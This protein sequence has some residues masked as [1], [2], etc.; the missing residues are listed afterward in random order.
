MELLIQEILLSLLGYTGDLI[1]ESKNGFVM[2]PGLRVPGSSEQDQ[3][4]GIVQLGWYY[5]ELDDL[6]KKRGFN[7]NTILLKQSKRENSSYSMGVYN[8]ISDLCS[9]YMSDVCHL[10]Q[11][12][13]GDEYISIS[14]ISQHLQKY[15]VIFPEI[16]GICLE[17]GENNISGC[18]LL[19]YFANLKHGNPVVIDVISRI[20]MHL[21]NIFLKQC[22]S[23]MLL[24]ELDDEN[25]EFF[26]QSNQKMSRNLSLHRN[27]NKK[28]KN[29]QFLEEFSSL[30]QSFDWNKTFSLKLDMI[31]VA[32]VNSRIA[33]KI[34]FC[35]KAVKLLNASQ[36]SWTSSD[37]KNSLFDSLESLENQ[38]FQYLL[39]KFGFREKIVCNEENDCFAELKGTSADSTGLQGP[40]FESLSN[41]FGPFLHHFQRSGYHWSDLRGLLEKCEQALLSNDLSVTHFEKLVNDLYSSVSLQLWNLLRDKFHFLNLL[42][43]FRN[44][45]LMGKGEFFQCVL[46]E[47]IQLGTSN[48]GNRSSASISIT[49]MSEKLQKHV[50]RSACKLL[51]L[52]EDLIDQMITIHAHSSQWIMD[53]SNLAT[54]A[55]K[56]KE[57]CLFGKCTIQE[58]SF[59]FP[60]S[61]N[62]IGNESSNTSNLE[63]SGVASSSR[64]S[65]S[66]G[67][68]SGYRGWGVV[69][70]P[71]TNHTVGF[72]DSSSSLSSGSLQSHNQLSKDTRRF[73]RHQQ[74]VIDRM[75]DSFLKTH[76]F[77]SHNQYDVVHANSSSSGGDSEVKQN[78]HD[79]N[80][81]IR[82]GFSLIE[83]KYLWKGFSLSSELDIQWNGIREHMFYALSNPYDDGGSSREM[84]D[85]IVSLASLQ[86]LLH[87]ASLSA[88]D[89]PE[90]DMD[91]IETQFMGAPHFSVEIALYGRT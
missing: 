80:N 75:K 31:P 12:A 78:I 73:Q 35:G 40:S 21:R 41:S 26:I 43:T 57:F 48:V 22:I 53:G 18:L 11:I 79:D 33:H 9:E 17:I 23:W 76:G 44:L 3:I 51:N 61:G 56:S 24:G 7:F 70:F 77:L 90:D 1:I 88:M 50:L 14:T 6:V 52:D 62:N 36:G 5:K 30:G 32:F 89:W 67:Y 19:D 84:K 71:V 45:F 34:L 83:S 4:N 42:Q 74:S 59:A 66:G 58:F 54:K 8:G 13:V 37:K 65:I 38:G 64:F 2:K 81:R 87:G 20:S 55:D 47:M 16:Y 63:K 15:S 86:F 69:L 91:F 72:N 27:F 60:L 25:K 39:K 10:E 82:G 46:D 68:E 49:A 85:G 28:T 29:F